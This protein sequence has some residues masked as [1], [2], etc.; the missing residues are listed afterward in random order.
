M[1]AVDRRDDAFAARQ[2]R[3]LLERDQRAGLVHGV[4]GHDHP[5]ARRDGGVER[6]EDHAGIFSRCCPCDLSKDDPV[7]LGFQATGLKPTRMLVERGQDLITRFEIESVEHEAHAF[8][9][10]ADERDLVSI[11]ADEHARL[12]ADIVRTGVLI[13]VGLSRILRE[14][15][16]PLDEREVHRFRRGPQRA[17]IEVN[18]VFVEQELGANAL[19]EIRVRGCRLREG[20]HRGE[21]RA[22]RKRRRP[23]CRQLP[24]DAA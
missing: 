13:R 9:R 8:G 3:Q 17:V 20:G 19:P 2:R 16:I 21:R 7:A 24:S 4:A 23:K 5:R 18:P 6:V 14:V 15:V 10:V 22:S 12:A 1:R 11:G